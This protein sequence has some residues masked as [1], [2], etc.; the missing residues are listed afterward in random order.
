MQTTPTAHDRAPLAPLRPALR[1][2]RPPAIDVDP[3][4]RRLADADPLRVVAWAA[5]RFGDGLVLS[6]SFGIQSAVML[7]MA[8]RVVPGI[9]VTAEDADER[10]TRFRGLEQECGLHLTPG[11]A[12][13]LDSSAL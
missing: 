1:L 11:L 4:N 3:A 6:T 13:S 10:A 7:H 5:D 2:V 12:E 9:P 8:T